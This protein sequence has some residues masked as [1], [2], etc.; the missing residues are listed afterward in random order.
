MSKAKAKQSEGVL[1]GPVVVPRPRSLL[2]RLR[3]G[4]GP[5]VPETLKQLLANGE[6]ADYD[7]E[8]A[9]RVNDAIDLVSAVRELLTDRS[10]EEDKDA[11]RGDGPDV[12]TLELDRI[13][14]NV[15]AKAKRFDHLGGRLVTAP[16]QELVIRLDRG[17]IAFF[18]RRLK[19]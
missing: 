14:G 11:G 9:N 3:E 18:R 4:S 2:D 17:Q 10:K 7:D 8:L 6:L 15:I 16:H 12:V 19:A 1:Q 13:S 5:G